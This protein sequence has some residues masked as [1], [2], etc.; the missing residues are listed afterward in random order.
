MYVY[1]LK[2]NVEVWVA[3]ELVVYDVACLEEQLGT[4]VIEAPWRYRS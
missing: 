2:Q 4:W 1:I 3:T